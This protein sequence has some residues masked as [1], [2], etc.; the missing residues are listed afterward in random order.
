MGTDEAGCGAF[1]I[2]VD[3]HAITLHAGPRRVTSLALSFQRI[4]EGRRPSDV[5]VTVGLGTPLNGMHAL[6]SGTVDREIGNHYP[7]VTP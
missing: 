1:A 4:C 5:S 7:E 2:T 6:A 3:V